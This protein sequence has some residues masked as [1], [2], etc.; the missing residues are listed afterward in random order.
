[1]GFEV[2]AGIVFPENKSTVVEYEDALAAQNSYG[3]WDE[4]WVADVNYKY[5][6]L[7]G[8]LHLIAGGH[9]VPASQFNI[10]I[11]AGIGYEYQ[12]HDSSYYVGYTSSNSSI[13]PPDGFSSRTIYQNHQLSFFLRFSIGARLKRKYS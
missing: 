6:S 13:L 5:N 11:E 9:V 8:S 4:Y 1:M 3:T 2:A 12:R 7:I 10:G